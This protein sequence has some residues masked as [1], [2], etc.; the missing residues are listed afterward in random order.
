M[1]LEVGKM[2]KDIHNYTEKSL[3]L[4]LYTTRIMSVLVVCCSFAF[5]YLGCMFNS[6][7]CIVFSIAYILFGMLGV[8][9]TKT[10]AST[11]YPI[12]TDTEA[13][14]TALRLNAFLIFLFAMILLLDYI[15]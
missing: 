7:G 10:G 12:Y 3:N 14:L 9:T 2:R 5:I 4:I 8:S 1:F 13:R 6:I 15:F 11:G